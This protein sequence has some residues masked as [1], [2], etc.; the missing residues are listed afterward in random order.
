[1]Q[2]TR[3]VSELS[4][5]RVNQK[6]IDEAMDIEAGYVCD[7]LSQVLGSAASNS[8]WITVQSH[9]NLIGVAVMTGIRAIIVSE[10][11]AIPEEVVRKADE[12]SIG[13]YSSPENGF[14]L[15]GQLYQM[16]IR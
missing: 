14:R 15:A 4:L 7:L 3:I 8:V 11:H 5:E 2:L 12:E 13:L 1:M 6:P 10:G 16:G 9:M